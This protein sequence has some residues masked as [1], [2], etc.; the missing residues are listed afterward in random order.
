MDQLLGG[1]ECNSIVCSINPIE[2]NIIVNFMTF[3]Q[4]NNNLVKDMRHFGIIDQDAYDN[5]IVEVNS[6]CCE[7]GVYTFALTTGFVLDNFNAWSNRTTDQFVVLVPMGQDCD[8]EIDEDMTL[9]ELEESMEDF[10]NSILT[11][12]IIIPFEAIE[13]AFD[14]DPEID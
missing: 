3:S 10:E 8:I 7:K 2:R 11:E 9:E 5:Q 4:Y 12:T 13:N 1:G 6:S 14:E